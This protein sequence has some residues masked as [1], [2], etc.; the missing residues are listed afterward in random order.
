MEDNIRLIEDHEEWT[1]IVAASES[2]AYVQHGFAIYNIDTEIYVGQQ[3][4]ARKIFERLYKRQGWDMRFARHVRPH[5]SYSPLEDGHPLLAGGR[6]A[7]YEWDFSKDGWWWA[8]APVD[9]LDELDDPAAMVF[10]LEEK[11]PPFTVWAAEATAKL[12][13]GEGFPVLPEFHYTTE[14]AFLDGRLLSYNDHPD[15][16]GTLRRYLRRQGRR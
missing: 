4:R 7:A 11:K 10:D 2:G 5:K 9:Y 14:A 16:E 8:W 13:N 12:T 15:A 3:H 6:T 1:R